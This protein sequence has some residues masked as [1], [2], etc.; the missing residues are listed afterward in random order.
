MLKTKIFWKYIKKICINLLITLDK[1]WQITVVNLLL[2]TRVH[3][4]A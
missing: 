4:Y 1:V 2:N 3:L